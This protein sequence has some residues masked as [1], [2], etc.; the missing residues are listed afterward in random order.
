MIILIS[1]K[2]SG[3]A[4]QNMTSKTQMARQLF[5]KTAELTNLF[6]TA[7]KHP[8]GLSQ[9]LILQEHTLTE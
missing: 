2:S 5:N 4:Q 3:N 1:P 8:K 9:L 7:L 6:H